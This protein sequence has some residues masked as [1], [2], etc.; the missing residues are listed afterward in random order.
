MSHSLSLL[1]LVERPVIN[2]KNLVYDFLSKMTD[3]EIDVLENEIA[4]QIN[5]ESPRLK[6]VDY[7]AAFMCKMIDRDIL[8][9][10]LKKGKD[11]NDEFIYIEKV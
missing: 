3:D 11:I 5:K 6:G 4:N 8:Y 2:E 10:L 1:E 9:Q 7:S